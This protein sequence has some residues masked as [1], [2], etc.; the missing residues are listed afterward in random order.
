MAITIVADPDGLRV[1][2]VFPGSGLAGT[3]VR[4]TVRRDG[5]DLELSIERKPLENR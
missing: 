5:K 4:V 3:F 1:E 2:K